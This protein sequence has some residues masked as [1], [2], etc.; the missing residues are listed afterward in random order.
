M[1]HR[2]F[3]SET[4]LER[5]E[6]LA[7]TASRVDNWILVE[8]RGAWASDAIAGSRLAGP[9]KAHLRERLDALRP[10]KALFI[11]RGRSLHRRR[12]TVFWGRSQDRGSQLFE[13]E[14]DGYDDL[15]E[16]DFDSPAKPAA[17]PLLL[18][19][20]HGKHDRCCA[21]RGRPLYEAL[22]ERVEEDWLWQV[23]HVGGDRF[24][25]NLVC[26]PEGLY[27]GRVGPAEAPAVLD[28]YLDGRIR[29]DCYRG[30]S[31]YPFPAQAAERRIRDELGLARIDELELIETEG[32]HDGWHVRFRAGGREIAVEV[33]LQ[34]GEPA[35][36]TCDA[37]RLTPPRHYVAGSPRESTA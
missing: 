13:A 11:R 26:L 14:I 5:A 32:G 18:V 27:F 4:S 10:A 20:T 3:C 17:H 35:C 7:A 9:V 15:L 29:L 34:P 16:L 21:R 2:P 25:G 30:R 33:A 6:T 23:S 31:A 37:E 36:L 12:L 8:Y 1:T 19:C 28:A 22:R 24:A